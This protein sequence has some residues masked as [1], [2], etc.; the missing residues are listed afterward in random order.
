MNRADS[1]NASDEGEFHS[2]DSVILIDDQ[3][4]DNTIRPCPPER[5]Q[6]FLKERQRM[7]KFGFNLDGTPIDPDGK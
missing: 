5:L 4:G 2:R 1:T 7:A 3:A 6:W